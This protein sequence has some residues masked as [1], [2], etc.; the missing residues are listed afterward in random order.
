MIGD[1]Q[2]MV[3]RT[4]LLQVFLSKEAAN[5]GVFEVSIEAP[6]GIL[7]CTCPG[8][9]ARAICRHT[10]IVKDRIDGNGGTYP[11]G[12][13]HRVTKED[14]DI[15]RLNDD[16]FRRMVIEHGQIEVA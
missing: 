11:W 5:L 13:D 10:K 4:R 14:I 8:Y 16:T 3:T 1:A 7:V 2:E 12:A 6:D 9:M 15:A